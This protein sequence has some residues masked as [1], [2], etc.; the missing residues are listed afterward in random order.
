MSR[1]SGHERDRVL[2]IG[3][4]AAGAFALV[5]LGFTSHHT[6]SGPR[7]TPPSVVATPEPIAETPAS[8]PPAPAAHGWTYSNETDKL[9]DKTLR[10]ACVDAN[11][12]VY[13]GTSAEPTNV[14]LCLRDDPK[15]GKIV[16]LVVTDGAFICVPEYIGASCAVEVRFNELKPQTAVGLQP[17]DVPRS[18][19]ILE[20]YGQM[21]T[22]LRN[23]TRFRAR[24][25]F[26]NGGYQVVD[27][28]TFGLQ[29]E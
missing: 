17:A 1:Q 10:S 23:S 4:L 21:S 8:I 22:A 5:F 12:P 13:L 20:P 14:A 15:Q 19:L 11:E 9:T 28:R 6:E 2:L 29:W 18:V 26:V 7:M 25:E 3:L 24:A 27:F 16:Y